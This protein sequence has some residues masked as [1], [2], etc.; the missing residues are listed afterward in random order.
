[1]AFSGERFGRRMTRGCHYY[2]FASKFYNLTLDMNRNDTSLCRQAFG[3]FLLF[4]TVHCVE[5]FAS[6][7]LFPKDKSPVAL[8]YRKI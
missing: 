3:M 1:M 6:F 7:K 4:Y 8:T 5:D 2:C